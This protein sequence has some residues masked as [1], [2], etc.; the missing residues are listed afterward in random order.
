[1]GK[2]CRVVCI[3]LGHYLDNIYS[4]VCPSAA[5]RELSLSILLSIR[6]GGSSYHRITK[7]K[8]WARKRQGRR[9]KTSTGRA[10]AKGSI[11]NCARYSSTRKT[12]ICSSFPHT[13]ILVAHSCLVSRIALV[14]PDRSKQI[15]TILLRMAQSGQLRNR[16]TEEQLIDLLNQVKSCPLSI[17]YNLIIL[18]QME[19][20][21]GK[22]TV[23]KSTIVVCS[24][25]SSQV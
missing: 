19:Q 23:Q 3:G 7:S 21:E 12:Y 13:Q 16:V 11:D 6:N 20:A 18:P 8:W 10:N 17:G 14:S 2:V 4:I 24:L 22:T 1:M 9:C 5:G 15:E 25:L